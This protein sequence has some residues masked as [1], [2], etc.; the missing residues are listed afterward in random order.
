[1]GAARICRSGTSPRQVVTRVCHPTVISCH[2]TDT[3]QQGKSLACLVLLLIAD[4]DT[5][6][7]Y[8]FLFV[9]IHGG[10]CVLW[11]GDCIESMIAR[12]SSAPVVGAGHASPAPEHATRTRLQPARGTRGRGARQ[13]ED[14]KLTDLEKEL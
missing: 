2:F 9:D 11:S 7:K 1:V 6:S 14:V 12:C 8:W 3:R 5:Y 10:E 13:M 4:L